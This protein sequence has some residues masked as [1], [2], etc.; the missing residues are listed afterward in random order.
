EG[1]GEPRLGLAPLAAHRPVGDAE[2]AGDLRLG[3]PAEEAV[4]DDP[5]EALVAFG[6]G[7]ERLIEGEEGVG[8]RLG[9]RHA[10]GE[11][12]PGL[13]A[14]AAAVLL[15]KTRYSTIRARRSSRSARA[16]RASSR[17]RRVSARS[18]ATAT[19]SS[20]ETGACPPPRFWRTRCRA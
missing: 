3:H 9:H 6:E 7:R 11:R 2:Q 12:A 15:P 10:P 13:C 17:A 16:V 5:A 14:A 19:A 8:A 20:S 1:G 18:S 4:L